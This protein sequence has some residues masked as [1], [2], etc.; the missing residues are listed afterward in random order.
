MLD[1]LEGW[2][3]LAELLDIFP[4]ASISP[5]IFV[6]CLIDHCNFWRET[7][8]RQKHMMTL[9]SYLNNSFQYN[10]GLFLQCHFLWAIFCSPKGVV[11]RTN[12]LFILLIA[13]TFDDIHS[14][15]RF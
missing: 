9:L 14:A 11:K 12:K 8:C 13:M 6:V 10:P 5:L 2:I 4:S 7:L 1:R 15:N 3:E